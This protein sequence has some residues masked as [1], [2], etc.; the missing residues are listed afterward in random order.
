M[1]FVSVLRSVNVTNPSWDLLVLVAFVVGIYL[2]IFRWGKDRTFIVLLCAY[3]ALALIDRLAFIEN[4]LGLKLENNFTNKSVLF[5]VG[6]I[7]L[8]WIFNKSDFVSIFK[9]GSKRAWFQTLVL[10]FLQVGFIISVVVSFLSPAQA[11]HLS[12]FLRAVFVDNTA[13]LF[14]LLSPLLATLLLKE[15]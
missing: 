12:I 5:L 15:Q 7:A 14:W 8:N 9:R 10:S 11:L 13:Q 6:I 2:Y 3:V 4:A 1:N